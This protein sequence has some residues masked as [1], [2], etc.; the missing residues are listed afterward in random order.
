MA[1]ADAPAAETDPQG[2][3]VEECSG[4]VMVAQSVPMVVD[5]GVF[6]SMSLAGI[7]LFGSAGLMVGKMYMTHALQCCGT[8][9]RMDV[10]RN[11][12]K[13][14]LVAGA[15]ETHAMK[16]VVVRI[17]YIGE[18]VAQHI[19]SGLAASELKEVTEGGVAS[20]VRQVG[21]HGRVL[22]IMASLIVQEFVEFGWMLATGQMSLAEFIVR[23]SEH[24][25]KALGSL[26]GGALG[27]AIGTIA[28]PGVGTGIGSVVGSMA[29][30]AVAGYAAGAVLPEPQAALPQLPCLDG[31]PGEG[32]P[33]GEEAGQSEYVEL[34]LE[35]RDPHGGEGGERS[36]QIQC[37]DVDAEALVAAAERQAAAVDDCAAPPPASPLDAPDDDEGFYVLDAAD[38]P[39]V[40]EA[41]Q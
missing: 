1:D 38:A 33:V 22:V 7:R 13:S 15:I 26:G 14:T 18:S 5:A 12:A 20:A 23:S 11:I 3:E 29:G 4:Y 21:I 6:Q 8:A 27:T 40:A 36:V 37:C 16:Y 34:L 32:A 35:Y 10:A 41:S 9:S 31:A 39:C 17:P 28:M 30:G 25:M 19:V 2:E 24:I